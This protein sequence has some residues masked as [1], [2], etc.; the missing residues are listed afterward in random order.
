MFKGKIYK[1]KVPESQNANRL[2]ET[3]ELGRVL[4]Q[5][6]LNTNNTSKFAIENVEVHGS[7]NESL[8]NMQT[9]VISSTA[10]DHLLEL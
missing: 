10:I 5:P 4:S 9:N 6:T 8:A 7:F 3:K 2:N 1:N